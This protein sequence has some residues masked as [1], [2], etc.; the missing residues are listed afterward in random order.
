[1]PPFQL[2][3]LQPLLSSY[4]APILCPVCRQGTL[5]LDNTHPMM[6]SDT[7]SRVVISSTNL[8]PEELSR[9]AP[10]DSKHMHSCSD[11]SSSTRNQRPSKARI[12]RTAVFQGAALKGSRLQ[13]RRRLH[14]RLVMS[15]E[16]DVFF[17][18]RRV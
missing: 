4:A 9:M 13:V 14:A 15:Q 3:L 16:G 10:C 5:W 18:G 6:A 1:M 8:L 11:G 2:P 17:S 12:P 7:R